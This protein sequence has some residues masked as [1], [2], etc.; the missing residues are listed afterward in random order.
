MNKAAPNPTGL[1]QKNFDNNIKPQD[2]LFRHVNG[3]WLK[4]TTIPQDRAISGSFVDLR[5]A[6]EAA[7]KNIIEQCTNNSNKKTSIEQKIG[8]LYKSF[9]DEEKIE[10]TGLNPI[11]NQLN[12]IANITT[13]T[14]IV[15]V[16]GENEICGISGAFGMYV[17]T[18]AGS[19]NRYLLHFYQGGLGLPDESYYREN[20]FTQILAAYEKHVTTMFTLSKIINPEKQAQ[21][22]INL[23]KDLAKAH[24][25]IVRCRDSQASYNLHNRQQLETLNF[26]WKIWQK[27]SNISDKILAETII[28][29]PEYF[30]QLAK[31][32]VTKNLDSWKAWL[33]WQTIKSYAPFLPENFVKEH[34]NFYGKT[35]SGTPE[36]RKRWKRAVS[37]V[38]NILGEAIGKMYVEKHFPQTAKTKME[39]LVKNLITAY[40]QEI[41]NLTWMGTETKKAALNKLEKFTPK[42]GYPN[43]WRNYEQLQINATNLLENIQNAATFEMQKE[44]NKIGLP[45][46]KTEWFMTP[47]T[48]NA[49]YNPGM[50]EIVFPAAILQP[51]FFSSNANDAVNYG[52]IGAVI[53]HEIGHGFDDQGAKYDGDGKLK[54]WWNETDK[55]EF[56]KLT[57][58][59]ISQYDELE[60]EETPGHKVNGALTVGENIGDLGGLTI[61]L[62]AYEICLKNQEN[63]RTPTQEDL[64]TFFLSWAQTWQSKI[65]P[66]EAIQRLSTD[67][68]SPNEFR[69]NTVVSNI[70]QYYTAFNVKPTDKMWLDPKKR[71]RIW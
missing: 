23:E 47:Q 19:P 48:V 18:D 2:D 22:V 10:K 38:E 40:G 7:I 44:L 41:K 14:E 9:M 27:T 16:M 36:I 49:Y 29:Q 69:C 68:H 39:I 43:K 66:E 53:G 71:V 52:A 8:D 5:D 46:D 11:K 15:E 13:I 60:P 56:E 25:D 55:L 31:L 50:N 32:L 35:L 3:T 28:A 37:L 42:I 6:S 17:N 65:R 70:E 58:K 30:Q 21:T 54:N 24:W 4:E 34:F 59:L 12:K 67:P 62:K 26:P 57:Q 1:I 45:V 64:Q 20:S 33:M 63:P 51:P 61:A